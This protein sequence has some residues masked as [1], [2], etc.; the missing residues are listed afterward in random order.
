MID[1]VTWGVSR[2]SFAFLCRCW[3]HVNSLFVFVVVTSH[4]ITV[5]VNSPVEMEDL[6]VFRRSKQIPILAV[7]STL[8]F[9]VVVWTRCEYTCDIIMHAISFTG[10][11]RR[12][13]RGKR[14]KERY[15][16]MVP[17]VLPFMSEDQL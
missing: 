2:L 6:L 15:R 12:R 4:L 14:N 8:S 10:K 5:T 11:K 1:I 16:E 9:I 3:R 13:K 7:S 17:F